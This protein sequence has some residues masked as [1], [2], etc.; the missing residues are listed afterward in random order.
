MREGMNSSARAEYVR[1]MHRVERYIDAH[2]SRNLE[3]AE[4][5]QV[6]HFSAFHFHRL[7]AAWMGETLGD[8]MRRRRVEVAALRLL[9]Q[10]S[11][12]VL[13]TALQ[14]GFGSGEA[15]ARAFRA[16]FGCSATEWRQVKAQEREEQIRNL[17]QAQRNLDQAQTG[18]LIDDAQTQSR[19][20]EVTMPNLNVKVIERTAKRVAY[21]RYVGP[22]GPGVN[23]F[24]QQKF[25]P[26]LAAQQLYGRPIYGISHDDPEITAP[27]KCRYDTCVEVDASYVPP[28]GVPITDI[29]PGRYAAMPFRG[30]PDTIGPAWKA[31]MRDWLPSS[32]YQL[33][34]RPTF[35]YYAPGA[36]F[37]LA[38][39]TFECDIVI[40][41]VPL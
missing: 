33:D 14:V 1:R 17:S 21:M 22:Y 5:A 2:L 27:Q 12:S 8:Y 19:V 25:H 31:L 32:G 38:T 9:T 36:Y 24:W 34:G 28:A 20:L 10:P 35:E 16:R 23:A 6:A 40:P 18:P 41:L 3:L 15:F 29:P 26:F 37:D 4:L 39:S 30:T 13:E 11:A 7:F